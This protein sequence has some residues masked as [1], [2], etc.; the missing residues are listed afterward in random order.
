MKER[1][2]PVAILA[3]GLF[4]VNIIARLV[5]RVAGGDNQDKQVWIGL[6]AFGV[7]GAVLIGAA[8][9]WACRYPTPRVLVDLL[10]GAGVGCLLSALVGPFVSG[11]QPFGGGFGHFLA[12]LFYY[13]V[14][15]A[16]GAMFGLL[17]VMI[18]GKDYKSQQ[19]KRYAEMM[20]ARPRRV[21]RR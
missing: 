20:R 5:V 17:A 19:L 11:G 8:Y 18:A 3:G 4:V 13:L 1:W 9:W 6:I 14:V 21:V 10:V 12:Q 7:V 16:V 2:L 15:A